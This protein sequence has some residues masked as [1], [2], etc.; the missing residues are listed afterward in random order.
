MTITELVHQI[1][2]AEEAQRAVEQQCATIDQADQL[3]QLL[4]E[5]EERVADLERRKV[6]ELAELRAGIDAHAGSV[7]E[8]ATAFQTAIDL[9]REA[10]GRHGEAMEERERLWAAAKRLVQLQKQID[11]LY[12]RETSGQAIWA[13]WRAVGGFEESR[14]D[15]WSSLKVTDRFLRDYLR[16]A[17]VSGYRVRDL[18]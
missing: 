13:F 1:A 16:N 6:Q 14:L 18:R 10:V 5:R 7:Q 17:G 11:G 8:V 15:V 2:Q 4:S 9:L 12:G 3:E